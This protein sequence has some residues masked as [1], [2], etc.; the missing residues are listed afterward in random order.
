MNHHC[1]GNRKYP[2]A[3]TTLQTPVA[4]LSPRSP[5]VS[6]KKNPASLP[7]ANP[8]FVS[9]RPCSGVLVVYSSWGSVVKLISSERGLNDSDA[10][11]GLC[12]NYKINRTSA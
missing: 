7:T 4:I 2:L 12:I 8:G 11:D 6:E 10:P 5:A 9:A 3:P 1:P